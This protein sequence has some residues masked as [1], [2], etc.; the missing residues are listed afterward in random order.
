MV[1][2]ESDP[3]VPALQ[4]SAAHDPYAALRIPGFRWYLA[5]NLL[6]L[7]GLNMQTTAISWEIY[8]RTHEYKF[9]GYV[10]LVQ[11]IPVI[12]L[13]MPAG[14]IIDRVDRKKLLIAALASTVLWSSGLALCSATVGRLRWIYLLLF[15]IGAA[16]S[17]VQ[18]ARSAF[19]PQ[20]VPRETFPNAVTWHSTGF[21]LST[22]IGPALGG[23]LIAWLKSATA[24]YVLTAV[25][26]LVN[27]GC[28]AMIRARAYVPSSEP[29]SI[30]SLLGG[31]SF[32][33]RSKIMLAA[34]TLDM[35]AVLLG[36]ATSLLPGFASDIL[37][38]GPTGYGWMRAAPGIGAVLMSLIVAHRPPIE[39]AGRTLLL[40]VAGF[41]AA[42]VVFGI[43]R[44]Y[45]LSLAMLVS[46][47]ALDMISVVIRHTLVQ[48]LTPDAMRGRVSAVN[49][50]FIGISN[51]LGEFES[52]V[53]AELFR[54]DDNK[55][56]GPTVSA[57]S[58]GVGTLMIVG[59]VALF[60]PP[61][62]RYGRLDGSDPQ[63][64]AAQSAASN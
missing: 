22:A 4:R 6:L 46:L 13:F 26:A 33:W 61:L 31:L 1:P 51:E 34:I 7:I 27:C 63:P 36:G 16:R 59:L 44:S 21:Q 29:P 55:E 64:A 17:F 43:S 19:L 54:R 60:S 52:A 28:L 10:G 9:L 48:L 41:G 25:L 39:R 49:G 23:L 53:V 24:V 50:M 57:V 18:P 40:S 37:H 2:A 32:V 3:D 12:G 14:H 56:F 8:E 58:G 35:F 20:I 45:T 5:G 38:A 30:A 42:T 11:I 62:R 47:G 15:L